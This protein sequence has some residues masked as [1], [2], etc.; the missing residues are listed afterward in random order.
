MQITIPHQLTTQEVRARL[1]AHAPEL[2]GG[3]AE[4]RASWHDEEHMDLA[5]KAMG[6]T[7]TGE[8]ALAPGEAIITIELPLAL[9]FMEST[10]ARS[11]TDKG[12]Q[13]LS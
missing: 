5:I 10:I 12:T 7:L 11:I 13:L 3:M 2:A 9:A 4:V 6:Q 1:D 8:I